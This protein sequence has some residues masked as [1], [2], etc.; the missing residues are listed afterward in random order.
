MNINGSTKLLALLGNPVEHTL[1]PNIH[2]FL[3]KKL[4]KNLVYLPFRVEENN[5]GSAINGCHALGVLGLNI[6]VPHKNHVMEYLVDID[7]AAK[8]IGAVNTLVPVEGGY[9]GYNT[10]MLGLLRALK[11]NQI[12]LKDEEVVILGAGGAAKAVVYMCAMEKAKVIYLANRT[13]QKAKDIAQDMNNHFK[14]DIVIPMELSNISE[15]PNH[16]YLAF[17]TTS[18]G[19]PA[20]KDQAVVE[21]ASFY[22]KV[23]TAVDLIYNPAQTKFMRLAKEAGAK[24]MNGLRMLLYQGLIAYELW[25]QCKIEEELADEVY[26]ELVSALEGKKK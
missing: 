9:K 20:T 24:T 8:A 2:N 25:N 6:T 12:S 19:L 16:S 21:E 26:E 22:E 5:L 10:D 14:K 7:D 17:Q 3:S 11:V 1:S 13:L 4:E 15:L 23:H 18:I